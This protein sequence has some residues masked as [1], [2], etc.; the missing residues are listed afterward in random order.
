MNPNLQAILSQVDALAAKLGVAAGQLY[1]I[2]LAQ[3][4]VE[5]YKDLLSAG[6]LLLGSAIAGYYI[7]RGY[8]GMRASMEDKGYDFSYHGPRAGDFTQ[9][10]LG[11]VL[12]PGLFLGAVLGFVVPAITELA[13]PQFWALQQL[14]QLF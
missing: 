5:G 10:I 8:R 1:Q 9:M 14:R 13:N 3:A 11:A 7:R 4:K 2:Y 12:C 6:V